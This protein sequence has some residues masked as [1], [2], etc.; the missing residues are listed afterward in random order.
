M[1]D[2]RDEVINFILDLQEIGVIKKV[3]YSVL[4]ELVE[5]RFRNEKD[6]EN[7]LGKGKNG[8]KA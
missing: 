4:F 1:R 6:I 3:D 7:T 2:L 5:I 8:D